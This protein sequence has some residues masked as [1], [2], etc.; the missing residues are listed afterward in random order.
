MLLSQEDPLQI[1]IFFKTTLSSLQYRVIQASHK[2]AQ[3]TIP[4]Q[5]SQVQHCRPDIGTDLYLKNAAILGFPML[6]FSHN[7]YPER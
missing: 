5:R 4:S 1:L 2:G 7:A 3:V 6:F